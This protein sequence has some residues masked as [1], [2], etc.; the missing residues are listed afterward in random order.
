VVLVGRKHG[1]GRQTLGWRG[2]GER[3]TGRWS[4]AADSGEL[5]M[6]AQRRPATEDD[7][8]K[9]PNVVQSRTRSLGI[10]RMLYFV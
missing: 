9:A 4:T 6:G 7:A 8:R 1:E 2:R 10:L 5:Q 3:H